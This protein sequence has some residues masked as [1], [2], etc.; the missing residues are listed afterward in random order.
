VATPKTAYDVKVA[1]V[2]GEYI[3][4]MQNPY[5]TERREKLIGQAGG[6]PRM[7]IPRKTV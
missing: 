2:A 4:W 7:K 3:W 1:V 6:C 5:L